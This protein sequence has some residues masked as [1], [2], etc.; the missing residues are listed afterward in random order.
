MSKHRDEPNL[1]SRRAFLHHGTSAGLGVTLPWIIPSS[2]WGASEKP[3][4]SERINVGLVG[5]GAMGRGHLNWCLGTRGVQLRAVCDVDAIRCRDAWKTACDKYGN[6]DCVAYNDYREM[7]AR[8]DIDG[9]LIATP[10]H[11]HTPI[12]VDAARAGKD[13]YGEKPVSL[14]I[15]EGRRLVDV[16]Q[17]YARVFQTGTQYRSMKTTRCVVNFVRNGGLGRVK[18]VFALWSR[19]SDFGGSYI[20]V[21]PPLPEEPV[22]DGL[23]WNL[24]VGPAAW[25]PY[26]SRYHRNPIPG[27]VPWAFCEDFGA[28]S[29]TW[30]HS[31]S[32]DVIQ[33]ALG[34]ERSGPVEI[35]HPADGQ[36]PTL[37]YRYAS[38]T[39]LHLVDHWGRV[40][41]DYGAVPKDARLEG[42]F[43]G[44][45][46]GERGW[47]SATYGKGQVE[48]SPESI[49]AEMGLTNRKVSGANDHHGNWLDCIR[50]RGQCSA[51]EE[52]G[53]RAASLGHLA[54]IAYK[55]GR[56]LKWDPAKEEFPGDAEANRLRT[57]A[58][59]EPWRI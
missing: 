31:H 48:G 17:R 10:D 49:F 13:I 30:H 9:I 11:W 34:M 37:T 54:I 25:H 4:P 26:N 5:I 14:T 12:A 45:F 58:S 44:I 59:R 32:A 28:A 53:H 38:G 29:V 3:V 47:V 35:L 42:S 51:D 46:V 41:S 55:L 20:P 39:L 33:Y 22:P 8:D 2:V 1:L 57:R 56:S 36:F 52:I 21:N 16:V 24:W 50:S 6:T 15:G 7:L 43:G 27:V 23:D 19:L 18:S 40:K